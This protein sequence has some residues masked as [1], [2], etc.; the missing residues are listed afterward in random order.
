MNDLI[1]ITGEGGGEKM[2]EVSIK[3]REVKLLQTLPD[4][5]LSFESMYRMIKAPFCGKNVM[6]VVK[7]EQNAFLEHTNIFNYSSIVSIGNR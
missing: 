6:K 7:S 1:N 4:C 3:P 2:Y 5:I